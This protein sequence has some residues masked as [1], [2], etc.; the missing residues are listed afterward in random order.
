M[1]NSGDVIDLDFGFPEGR[2]AGFRRHAVV[3]SAQRILDSTP[4]V[5]QVVPVTSTVRAFGSE[6]EVIP[7]AINGFD[8]RSVA[9]CQHIR[10]VSTSRTFAIRGNV[11]GVVL[12]QIRETLAVILDLQP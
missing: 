1:L 11:G 2:E 9:Q 10:A 8:E 3:V 4:S 5:I 12:A 6:V 7:D